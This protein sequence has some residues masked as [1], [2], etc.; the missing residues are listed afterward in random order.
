MPAAAPRR[1]APRRTGWKRFRTPSLVAAALAAVFVTVAATGSAGG[2]LASW[3]D[4]SAQPASAISAASITAGST[5]TTSPA[6]TFSAGTTEKTGGVTITN[7]GSVDATYR[8][9]TTATGSSALV[10]GVQVSVWPS[11]AATGCATPVSPVSGTWASLPALT[12]TLAAG[13]SQF[14]CVKTT[15][16]TAVGLASDTAVTA[17]FT[18]TLSRNNWTSQATSTVTQK[19]IDAAPSAP[20][21]LSF[22]GTTATSTTLNWTASTDDVDV[23]GYDVYRGTTLVGSTTGDTSL[24][25]TGLSSSTAYSYTVR[26]R[27]GAEHTSASSAVAS[28]TT[29]A[30][31]AP[32]GWFQLVNTKSQ[33]C[34]DAYGFGTTNFTP[35]VQWTCSTPAATNQQWTFQGPNAAGFYTVVPRHSSAIIWD[36]EAA[37]STNAARIILYGP[38][39]GTNQQWSVIAVGSDKYQFVAR[40]SGKCMAVLGG[41]IANNVGFEQVT[42]N[43]SDPAQTFSLRGIDTTAPSAPALTGSVSGTTASLSWSAATDA[44]G[45]S[46]YV[47]YRNG[48]QIAEVASTVRTY[49]NTGLATGT[50]YAYTVRAK[51]AANNVSAVSNTVSLS[52]IPSLSC[53]SSTWMATFSWTT[54]TGVTQSSLRYNLYV[55][56]VQLSHSADGWNSYVQLTSANVPTSIPLGRSTVLVTRV[57]SNG[58]ETAIGSGVV[59]IQRFQNT[60]DRTF[61]CG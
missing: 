16:T 26:A 23:T 20:T 50:T 38:N 32:S 42:C 31:S 1:A 48:A 6:V 19:F 54:P 15:L 24:I 29:L 37:S 10:S 49:S 41:S 5:V 2:T 14:Y 7:T 36:V 22:S 12:G 47:V 60:N 57:L 53:S 59:N 18:T 43:A 52:T 44:V 11:T 51:D 58:S 40:N 21:G 34:I 28:V 61:A 3:Y 55:N 8:T 39:S 35:L 33:M 25:I 56:G 17:T 13:A 46:G 45:V 27:D 9:V 4:S 30:V